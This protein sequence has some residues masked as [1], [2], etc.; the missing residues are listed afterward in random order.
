MF[1]FDSRSERPNEVTFVFVLLTAYA[2][3]ILFCII[4]AIFD[5]IPSYSRA[6]LTTS[7]SIKIFP[8][9]LPST[10]QDSLKEE[11]NM[12]RELQSRLAMAGFLQ[13]T[14]KSLVK[15]KK[16]GKFVKTNTVLQHFIKM[17][18][19]FQYNHLPSV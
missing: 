12:K 2:C 13:E 6:L 5:C 1:T 14:L 17:F 9:M 3:C 16:D 7:A 4:F 8:N 19:K 15:E 10:F 11:E 18:S